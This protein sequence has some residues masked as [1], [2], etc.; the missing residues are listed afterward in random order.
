MSQ[1]IK[2]LA[3]VNNSGAVA[4]IRLNSPLTF[5]RKNGFVDFEIVDITKEKEYKIKFVP[6]IVIIQRINNLIYLDFIR[7][8]KSKGAKIIYEIDDN[9][10][11]VPERNPAY[12]LYSDPV[13]RR[14]LLEFIWLSD[15]VTVSTQNLKNYFSTYNENIS[16]IPNQIDENIFIPPKIAKANYDEIR[17]GFA[18]T[19]THQE[20]FEQVIPALLQLKKYYEKKIKLVFIN[21]LPVEF[22]SYKE[23]EFI[24]G[25]ASLKD[26][27]EL[28]KHANLDIG[29]APLSFNK[30]NMAKSDIKFLEYGFSGIAGVYSNFGPYKRSVKNLE[31]GIL[32]NLENSNGWFN[33]LS[34]L[35][36]NPSEIDRIKN[37]VFNYVNQNRTINKNYKNWLNV[38]NKVLKIDN[39]DNSDSSVFSKKQSNK[40]EKLCNLNNI[41]KITSIIALTYNQ[42]KYT[43]EFIES[44]QANTS[45][46]QL[47][48]IDN[49]STDGTKEYLTKLKKQH[50][51]VNV[52]F[53][54]E[55]LGFPKAINQGILEA[56]GNYVVLLNNDVVVTK[57]WL[58]RMIEIADSDNK[59]GIVG[60]I[61]NFVS[62]VQIDKNAKYNSI[63]EMHKYANRISIE[64]K[65]QIQEFPRVAFLC[66]LIKKEVIEKIGGLD[67]RFS[68]GN[69][70]DDDFCLRAQL[71][72]YKTVIAKD[73]FIHHYGSVSFKANGENNY[74]E[75]LK[76]NKQKFI[77]KWGADPEEI[78]LK[79]KLWKNRNIKIPIYKDLFKQSIERTFQNID[80]NEIDFAIENIKLSIEYF[81]QSDR[82]GYENISK[83]VLI[84]IAGNL[85]LSNNELEE[86]KNWFEKE[87]EINP[88]SSTACFGLGEIFNK[89][90]MLEE[91]KAMLEWAVVN[92]IKNQNAKIKLEEVN[93][94]LNLSVDHNSLLIENI[95][96]KEI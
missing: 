95:F 37:N 21:M 10:L 28:L 14:G 2:I 27:Y 52:I 24:P 76:I 42:L 77:D 47:I 65:N 16:V 67:E 81:D 92:N 46:Y 74:S 72:G 71:A 69:F 85:A 90:E 80:E 83:E 25:A 33:K 94:K 68:P 78:W 5:L 61:S 63:D 70:E 43:K 50:Q 58:D 66:T 96:D 64:N 13:N 59:I 84:N 32:V 75:R 36:E 56:N 57:D 53:N 38:F 9:L 26:F 79:G 15:H 12:S 55:N 11:E 30:F 88:N 93:Q 39:I 31:N 29:L 89:A 51:N 18:G 8:L 87:L 45:N 86:A 3:L 6:D 82:I 73:V 44:V 23:V 48:I 17:I 62:G 40:N 34:Y 60:P 7:L 54:E 41:N 91:S 4:D 1:K 22:I 19:I 49:N 35:V 20:D